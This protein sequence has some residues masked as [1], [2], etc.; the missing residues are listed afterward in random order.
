MTIRHEIWLKQNDA[1]FDLIKWYLDD[2]WANL[3]PGEDRPQ[4]ILLLAAIYD[5]EEPPPSLAVALAPP[6]AD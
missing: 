3:P 2:F 6:G 1:T 5:P 4:I